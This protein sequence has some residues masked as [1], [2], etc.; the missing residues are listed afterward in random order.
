VL[1]VDI[2]EGPKSGELV[3]LKGESVFKFKGGK[4]IYIEDIS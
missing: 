1:N 2:P 3:K 4:I